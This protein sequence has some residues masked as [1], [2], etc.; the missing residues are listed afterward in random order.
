[1]VR[2]AIEADGVG[3]DVGGRPIIRDISLAVRQGELVG[4]MGNSG[5]G[6]S[7]LLAALTG[8]IPPSRG[9]VLV[10]GADL[11]SHAGDVRGLIGFVPQDDIMHPDLTV[12][13]ALWYSARLRMPREYTDDQVRR[14][15]FAV[16]E[17]FGLGDVM[18][19]RIGSA[20][21]R[22]I[23]GG[24]RKR[25]SV[26]MEL[27]TDPPIV[28]LDEPTSGL[29][30]VDALSLMK[31]L[32]RLADS[33]KAIML[34]I[35]QPGVEVMRL[36]DGLAVV[37]RDRSSG[38]CGVLI[39]YGPAYPEA[40]AFFEPGN[41]NPDAEAVMRGLQTGTVSH[42]RSAYANSPVHEAW[43]VKRRSAE[44]SPLAVADRRP[45]G[46][47]QGVSQ[48][49]VLM[50]RGL[51]VKLADAWGTGILIAQAPLM[52]ILVVIV[53]GG[54]TTRVV[55]ASNW[56]ETSTAVT[57]ATYLMVLAAVW[58]GC[59]SSVREVV[60]E[61]SIFRRERMV[62]V[63]LLPYLASKV[64]LLFAV[65]LVQCF[66]LLVGIGSGCGFVADD[67]STMLTLLL[68]ANVAVMI[69][70]CVSASVGSAEAAAGILPLIILPMVVLGGI[71]VPLKDLTPPARFLTDLT[72]SR[73]AFER[74]LVEEAGAR[75]KM[76]FA[77]DGL[78]G[79]L[80]V[81]DMAEAAFPESAGRCGDLPPLLVLGAMWCMAL[82]V[83][84]A[85]MVLRDRR[86][87]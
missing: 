7:T 36:M 51:A 45:V 61:R 38:H 79:A 1:M 18:N 69:G 63:G 19:S 11:Y 50:R 59:S 41:A 77:E 15:I 3:V 42:W 52:A 76:Q 65:S 23:S 75:P 4:V 22:G 78:P 83:L 48:L 81:V 16:I 57:T 25:V 21:R 17:R 68:A 2:S 54:K 46:W 85:I 31:L 27:V 72:P 43:V 39:W 62:G 60:T 33:G 47:L 53:F 82:V 86:R 74:A 9:R 13:Q 5:A 56:L 73:W 8:S 35:H 32:R 49:A 24:Q 58:L 44:E 80:Q 66:L 64:V 40:A 71:L 30:S 10:S 87:M 26:A 29:S 12:W 84:I 70:L 14:R 34:T 55:D 67:W 37:A 6:K 20:H 28:V